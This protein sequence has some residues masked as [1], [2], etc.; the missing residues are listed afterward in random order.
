MVKGYR[1]STR[2]QKTDKSAPRYLAF[3]EFDSTALGPEFPKVLNT[4][5]SKQIL[6]NLTLSQMDRWEYVSEFGKVPVGTA[7]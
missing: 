5:W 4:E 7:F 1:R 2:Y 6:G 3:H